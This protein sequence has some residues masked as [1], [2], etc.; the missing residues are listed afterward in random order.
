MRLTDAMQTA[1]DPDPMSFDPDDTGSCVDRLGGQ[2]PETMQRAY[3]APKPGKR[4]D[5]S[6]YRSWS[7]ITGGK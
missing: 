3:Q 7:V 5:F 4:T 1:H 6:A 2:S